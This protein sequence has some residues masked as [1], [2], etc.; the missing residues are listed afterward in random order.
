MMTHQ[1]DLSIDE[2]MADPL[3]RT[4]MRADRVEPRRLESMLRTLASVQTR[5]GT[6]APTPALYGLAVAARRAASCGSL[7]A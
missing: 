6:M 7:C 2:A 5:R 1:G 3:I 4:V